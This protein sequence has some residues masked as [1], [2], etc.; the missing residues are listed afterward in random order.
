MEEMD[1]GGVDMVASA[2]TTAAGGVSS[3]ISLAAVSSGNMASSIT[4][5]PRLELL[6]L[7]ITQSIRSS[8]LSILSCMSVW[9]GWLNLRA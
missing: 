7:I 9:Q 3:F 4:E 5:E 2:M 6:K 8:V 1:G